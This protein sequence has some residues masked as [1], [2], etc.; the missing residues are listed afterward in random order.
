MAIWLKREA[1]EQILELAQEADKITA[2]STKKKSK[3]QKRQARGRRQQEEGE[4]ED[5]DHE[6]EEEGETTGASSTSSSSSSST[7]ASTSPSNK[8]LVP[9]DRPQG[10]VRLQWD[11][12][13]SPSGGKMMRRAIQLGLRGLLGFVEGDWILD[14]QDISELVQEQS[15]K[16]PTDLKVPRERVYIPLNKENARRIRVDLDREGDWKSEAEEEQKADLPQN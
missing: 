15:N 12:D 11:P 5:G 8:R 6:E 10:F 9:G 1:F 2:S 7:P 14:I 16:A 3:R 4:G 13:H